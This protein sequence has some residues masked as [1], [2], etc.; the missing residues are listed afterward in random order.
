MNSQ[1][2]YK[3]VEGCGGYS[4]IVKLELNNDMTFYISY[5]ANEININY[6]G[7]FIKKGENY[8]LAKIIKLNDIE[9]KTGNHELSYPFLD[10]YLFDTLND[11]EKELTVLMMGNCPTFNVNFNCVIYVNRYVG[12]FDDVDKSK[13]STKN[14]NDINRIDGIK[15]VSSD[16]IKMYE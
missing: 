15:L 13:L 16:K 11:T 1:K 3:N 14:I 7:T 10:I 8:Y 12:E 5:K 6:S 9:I 4:K 2:T